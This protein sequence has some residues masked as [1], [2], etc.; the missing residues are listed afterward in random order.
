M[1]MK[2]MNQKLINKINKIGILLN[3]K[4]WEDRNKKMMIMNYNKKVKKRKKR[5]KDKMK[6]KIKIKKTKIKINKF[7]LPMK[8]NNKK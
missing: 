8:F 1:K 7:N 5:K 3:F 6:M 2:M 4:E